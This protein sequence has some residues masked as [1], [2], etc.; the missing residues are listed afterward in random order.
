MG[1]PENI[2]KQRCNL[3]IYEQAWVLMTS[4]I[5]TDD[6]LPNDQQPMSE[7]EGT[8]FYT[9]GKIEDLQFDGLN[10][11]VVST[12]SELQPF[13]NW[14]VNL[15][16]REN[17]FLTPP[18]RAALYLGPQKTAGASMDERHPVFLHPWRELFE[19]M[20][21]PW[22]EPRSWL[23]LRSRLDFY[24]KGRIRCGMMMLSRRTLC[25]GR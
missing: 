4:D 15:V 7:F 25:L 10:V 21:V 17:V 11:V 9:T 8:K 6:P 16:G 12:K 19:R 5:Q 13:D 18:N 22:P 3:S 23:E 24:G 1:K 2:N 14:W 20:G